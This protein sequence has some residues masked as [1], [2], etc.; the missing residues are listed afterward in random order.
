MNRINNYVSRQKTPWSD[1]DTIT[2]FEAFITDTYE[3]KYRERHK[4]ITDSNESS[5]LNEYLPETCPYCESKTFIK[6]G[7]YKNGV[8]KFRCSC[9]GKSFNILTNTIF[10]NHKISISEWIEFLLYLFGY[11]SIQEISKS[12]KNSSTT[13]KY[14]LKKL[15]LILEHYQDNI[16]LAGKIYLDEM[17]YKIKQSDV[18][19]KGANDEFRGLSQNQICVGVAMSDGKIFAK[20]EGFGKTNK[21][22]TIRT[23]AKHIMPKSHLIHDEDKS[24]I[25]LVKSFELTEDAYNSK[26][27]KFCDD[28]HNPLDPINKVIMFLK[29]FLNSHPGF[30]RDEMQGYIDLFAFM[31]NEQGEPLAKVKTIL[32]IS[33]K[34]RI[35][36]K[37]R[38]Y[39][40][41]KGDFE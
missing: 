13:S 23:F 26:L 40:K 41:K 36:L 22:K 34:T 30:N 35:S 19:L 1:S 24:H 32:D 2:S 6:N 14:W 27:L 8:Q 39:Y 9:C 38:E 5:F 33:I 16:V 11:E 25:V 31:T 3:S 4:S 12:N 15:F 29:K 28:Q 21:E 18:K 7:K 37:Y 20:I 10:D 17:Y